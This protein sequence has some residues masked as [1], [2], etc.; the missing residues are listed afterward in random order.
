MDLGRT[1]LLGQMGVL[2][3]FFKYRWSPVVNAQE[4]TY[5]R[6][7]NPFQ[8]FDL[9][10]SLITWDEKYWYIDQR[11]EVKGE[12]YAVGIIRGVFVKKGK[13]LPV[14]EAL[15]IKKGQISPVIP[16]RIHKWKI[17][18]SQKKEET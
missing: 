10:T 12:V 18:L 11:F 14:K 16:K 6:A 3:K 4:I 2:K 9:K 5:I 7:I 1:Y 8:K 13:V 17:F 15:G